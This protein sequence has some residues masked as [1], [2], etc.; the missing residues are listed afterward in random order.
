LSHLN[1]RDIVQL[2]RRTAL[3]PAPVVRPTQI[4]KK[5]GNGPSSIHHANA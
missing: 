2:G 1:G 5:R 4:P 3:T